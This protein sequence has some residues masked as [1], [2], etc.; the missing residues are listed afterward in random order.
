MGT[1]EQGPIEEFMKGGGGLFNLIT[2]NA[3]DMDGEHR[4]SMGG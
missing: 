3:I 4:R 2:F 1:V